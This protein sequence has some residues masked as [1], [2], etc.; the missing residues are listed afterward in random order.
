MAIPLGAFEAV[1]QD[2]VNADVSVEFVKLAGFGE[3]AD[4][5]LAN[6]QSIRAVIERLRAPE[7]LRTQLRKAFQAEGMHGLQVM[8]VR[9]T[10]HESS[11]L[12][13]VINMPSTLQS[14]GVV[15]PG[16]KRSL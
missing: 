8:R 6:L 14:R 10:A 15:C 16:L 1:L 9:R 13:R 3:T 4:A 5:N 12:I 7:S 11:K 2:E